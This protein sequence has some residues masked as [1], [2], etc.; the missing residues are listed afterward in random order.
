MNNKVILCLLMVGG[1]VWGSEHKDDGKRESVLAQQMSSTQLA[2]TIVAT[3][4]DV[5]PKKLKKKPTVTRKA[6]RE[7]IAALQTENQNL[8]NKME[9]MWSVCEHVRRKPWVVYC[10]Y[11]SKSTGSMSGPSFSHKSFF[12]A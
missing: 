9:N 11:C 4:T 7:Q 8:K 1:V 6:L 5:Q 3:T 10:P 12:S 2:T